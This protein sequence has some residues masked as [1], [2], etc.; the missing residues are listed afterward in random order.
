MIIVIKFI[1]YII[2]YNK[3]SYSQLSI[4][5]STW[6]LDSDCFSGQNFEC[7][8]AAYVFEYSFLVDVWIFTSL[9]IFSSI[10]PVATEH[11]ALT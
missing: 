2:R 9:P 10:Y 6:C 7:V 1:N 3:C 4:A 5:S 11:S 8:F